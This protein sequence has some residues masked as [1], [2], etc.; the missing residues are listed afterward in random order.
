MIHLKSQRWRQMR[1]PV[2]LQRIQRGTLLGSQ[3]PRT[4]KMSRP[5]ADAHS[6]VDAT[7]SVIILGPV[8]A[9]LCS[10]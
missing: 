7:N 2:T 6:N 10:M 3:R 5:S 1:R 8:F 4:L 9:H